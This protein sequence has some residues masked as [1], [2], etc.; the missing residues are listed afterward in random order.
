MTVN[1]VAARV[2]ELAAPLAKAQ[3][4]ELVDVEY[5]K[6]G[7]QWYLRLFIDKPGGVGLVDCQGLSEKLDK[8]LDEVDIIPHA[9]FLEVSS[10][11]LER[12]LKKR[13]DYVRFE[14]RLANIKTFAPINGR[15][16]FLG[17]IKASHDDGVLLDTGKEEIIIPWSSIASARL[18][19]EL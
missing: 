8:V 7:G 17:R 3:G 5:V 13:E 6:E 1:K 11:G 9:Y 19:L 2:E 10:P 12:P 14:G 16:R 15:K 18:A 4:V